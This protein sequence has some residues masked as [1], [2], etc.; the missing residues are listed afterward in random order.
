MLV[1]ALKSS[2][3][4][5]VISTLLKLKTAL[6]CFAKLFKLTEVSSSVHLQ[7]W[8]RSYLRFPY[9]FVY[10]KLTTNDG[11]LSRSRGTRKLTCL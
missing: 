7:P 2:S 9:Y 5:Y 11:H 10:V 8:L 1:F 3:L 6:K 4:A